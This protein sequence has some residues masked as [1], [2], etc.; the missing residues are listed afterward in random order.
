MTRRLIFTDSDKD[1]KR[2]EM[3][4]HAVCVAPMTVK[5]IIDKRDRKQMKLEGSILDR[6]EEVSI[7]HPSGNE[8]PGGMKARTLDGPVIIDMPQDEVSFLIECGAS[9]QWLM[10]HV[11]AAL[12]A[13]E[14]LE[15]APE[16]DTARPKAVES[17]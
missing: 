7:E 12:D 1:R 16:A 3:L 14:F 5:A 4:W 6:F 10:P 13:L 15:A 8:L 11:R 17:A 9:T 2:F